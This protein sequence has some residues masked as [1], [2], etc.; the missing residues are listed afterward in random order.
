MLL[1][2]IDTHPKPF[3]G[4]DPR[5][6]KD[7]TPTERRDATAHDTVH[8]DTGLATDA[9]RFYNGD[10][11]N[12]SVDFKGV[13]SGF[14]S[15]S[16]VQMTGMETDEMHEAI[17]VVENFLRYVLQ[18]DVCPEYEADVSGALQVCEDARIE[19]PMIGRLQ[20]RLPGAFNVAARDS[21]PVAEGVAKSNATQDYDEMAKYYGL[22]PQA[23]KDNPKMHVVA[24]LTVLDEKESFVKELE[25]ESRRVTMEYECTLDVVEILRP[26][27]S[28]VHRFR[29]IRLSDGT[30][31]RS[32]GSAIFR[33]ATIESEF[34]EPVVKT[35]ASGYNVTLFFDDNILRNMKKGMKMTFTL[36]QLD[37][38]FRFVKGLINI[39]PS[40]HTFLPQELMKYHKPP[41]KNN[42]PGPSVH[43]DAVDAGEDS[44][45][46]GEGDE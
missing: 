44:N 24:S 29:A 26:A 31:I 33:P 45:E 34:D 21:F 23:K 8:H 3:V 4:Q 2:G 11:E 6:L 30:K 41:T 37:N 28:I 14:L 40:F 18:H 7:L 25:D 42:R 46:Q 22:K 36:A 39:V 9:E 27:D 32:I 43:G 35:P 16:L 1:G 19:W 5:E 17:G 38:G 13:A 15:Q 10:R 20:G 12:W